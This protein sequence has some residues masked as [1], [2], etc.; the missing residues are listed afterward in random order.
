MFQQKGTMFYGECWCP[1][2]LLGAV[3][4]SMAEMDFLFPNLAKGELKEYDAPGKWPKDKTPP[5]YFNLNEFT[6]SFQEIIDTYGKPNY[7]E[8]NPTLFSIFT[9]PFLFGMMFGDIGHGSL[10]TAFAIYLCLYKDTIGRK[11]FLYAALPA[12][13][14]LLLMGTC[15][16]YMGFIYNDFLSIPTNFFGTNWTTEPDGQ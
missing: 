15:S 2:S 12:R 7:K 14:L 9:F 4:T 5:S 1:L 8:A 16:M 11:N 6:A 10:M 13:Y 3:R